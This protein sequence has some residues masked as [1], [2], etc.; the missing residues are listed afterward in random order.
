M[1]T[2][3]SVPILNGE[4]LYVPFVGAIIERKTPQGQ[5]QILVQI[6]E[7]AS[8]KAYSGCFEIPGGKMKA[9]EDIYETVRREVYEESGIRVTFIHNQDT[10]KD[11]P[12]KDDISSLI[13]PFCVTQMSNGPFI[14]LVF[15]CKGEGEP[16]AKTEETKEARWVDVEE[17]KIIVEKTPEKVFTALLAP[18]KKY[19]DQQA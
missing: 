6:R 5:K 19:L 14:G 13:E 17:F 10:R 1:V 18:L 3:K 4:A 2:Q 15:L 16:V 12:N 9:F 7:K 11:Y 8:D